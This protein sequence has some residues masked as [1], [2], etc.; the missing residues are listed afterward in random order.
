MSTTFV[1][2]LLRNTLEYRGHVRLAGARLQHG[3]TCRILQHGEF[4]VS[5]LGHDS[6]LCSFLNDASDGSYLPFER[7]TRN[8]HNGHY[9]RFSVSVGND[10]D[11]WVDVVKF[12]WLMHGVTE[13]LNFVKNQGF[14]GWCKLSVTSRERFLDGMVLAAQKRLRELGI[15]Y[16]EFA[17][18]FAD[19]QG[20]KAL[21]DRLGSEQEA[22]LV[23]AKSFYNHKER[24]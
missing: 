19:V 16:R 4:L 20:A 14:I 22:Y 13:T 3:P 21:M 24:E 17:E 18:F 2:D 1:V 7:V 23:D 11:Q 12:N 9:V 5:L 6:Q 15:K 10:F 8:G